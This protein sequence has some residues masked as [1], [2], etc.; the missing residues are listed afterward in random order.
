M[1]CA[2]SRVFFKTVS[3]NVSTSEMLADLPNER[4]NCKK[5]RAR[6]CLSYEG[7]PRFVLSEFTEDTAP[8]NVGYE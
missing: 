4:L 6:P 1:L 7:R 3:T 5:E 2:C 8:V